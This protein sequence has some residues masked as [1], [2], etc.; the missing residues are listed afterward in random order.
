MKIQNKQQ[1][2]NP[3]P[4]VFNHLTAKNFHGIPTPLC[5]TSSLIKNN[6]KKL[7]YKETDY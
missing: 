4:E 2:Q 6:Y 1:Y 5:Q 7:L 3:Q